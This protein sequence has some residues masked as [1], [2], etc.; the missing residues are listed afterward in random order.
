MKKK[1]KI[2][3][4]NG[5]EPFVAHSPNTHKQKL[6]KTN[7]ESKSVA[8][9]SR[10]VSVVFWQ[11]KIIKF[12]AC[13]EPNETIQMKKK[14]ITLMLNLKITECIRNAI[15]IDNQIHLE[16]WRINLFHWNWY[17]EQTNAFSLRI[18]ILHPPILNSHLGNHRSCC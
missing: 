9:F 15:D 12:G 8:F 6:G 7:I 3:L 4:V 18:S 14:K 13:H 16:L 17:L 1:N 5:L 11:R 2:N 10:L